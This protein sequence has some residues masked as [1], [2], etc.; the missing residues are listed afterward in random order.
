MSYVNVYYNKPM[1]LLSSGRSPIKQSMGYIRPEGQKWS[2][3]DFNWAL[4]KKYDLQFSDMRKWGLSEC[5][6]FL[7]TN[8]SS[9]SSPRT[10]ENKGILHTRRQQA[11]FLQGLKSNGSLGCNTVNKQLAEATTAQTKRRLESSRVQEDEII[12]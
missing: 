4:L 9:S 6:V 7:Q 3:D 2:L 12:S 10:P 8:S 1:M 11:L 5:K